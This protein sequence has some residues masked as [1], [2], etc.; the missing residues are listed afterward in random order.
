M[1]IGGFFVNLLMTMAMFKYPMGEDW[2][3]LHSLYGRDNVEMA[4]NWE[5]I[6]TTN[7][8]IVVIWKCDLEVAI[9]SWKVE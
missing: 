3:S 9:G 7:C 6:V 5:V 8:V 2:G 4:M 1:V